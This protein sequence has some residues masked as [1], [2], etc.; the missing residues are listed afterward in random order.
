[1]KR[2]AVINL[3]LLPPQAAST[4]VCTCMQAHAHTRANLE[5]CE[6]RSSWTRTTLE[7]SRRFGGKVAVPAKRS[8]N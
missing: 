2:F 8:M 4:K 5:A 6:R 3:T 1:M 7:R